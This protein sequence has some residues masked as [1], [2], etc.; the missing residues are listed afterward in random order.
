MNLKELLA[1]LYQEARGLAD[2]SEKGELTEAEEK[3]W[4]EL[5]GEIESTKEKLAAQEARAADAAEWRKADAD[6]NA[7]SGSAARAATFES[8]VEQSAED[9]R[10]KNPSFADRLFNSEGFVDYRKRNFPKGDDSG[11]V[12]IQSFFHRDAAIDVAGFTAQELRTLIYSGALPSNPALIAPTR[13]PGIY[14]PDMPVLT[15]RQAFINLQT[16]SNVVQFFRELLFTNNAAFVSDATASSPTQLGQSGVKPESALTFEAD[17]NVV[18]TLAHWIPVQNN[19]LDDLPQLRGII[20]GRL[21]D[22]LKLAEDDAIINGT[23]ATPE[24]EGLDA[25]TGTQ[26][27]D[28]AY[29]AANPVEN[30]GNAWE[31]FDRITRG[32][33]LVR[34][35]GRARPS[36]V[37]LSPAD[38]ERFLSVTDQNGQYFSGSPFGDVALSRMRGLQ[39]FETEALDEGTAWV[40]DGRMAAVFD[41]MDATVVAGWINDYLIRNMQV[42]LAEERLAFVTFRPAAFCKVTLTSA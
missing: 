25:V 6:F 20:D 34:I 10:K 26:D 27:A 38:L 39:V 30:A 11:R 7:G 23:G 18:E 12:N 15:V 42:L 24:L 37:F 21:I 14:V 35:T 28:A 22:G 1:K 19:T 8:R 17:S 3:R 36:F 41:R 4:A 31:D 29:F 16:T 32:R 9:L 13:V 2:A 5:K 33:R 40:G